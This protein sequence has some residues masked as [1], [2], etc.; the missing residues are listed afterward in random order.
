MAPPVWSVGQVL[1]AADVNSWFIPLVA[2]KTSAQ[3]VTSSTTPVNDTQLFLTLPVNTTYYV[4][5]VVLFD[6]A[7]GGDIKLNIAAPA[8]ATVN[9]TSNNRTLAGVAAN[10][11]PM[12]TNQIASAGS[13]A[14]STL[15]LSFNGVVAMGATAGNIQVVWAQNTSSATATRVLS[16]S[17]LIANR[18]S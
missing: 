6:A 2:L 12:N 18:I 10:W 16:A 8:G 5:G 15:T 13:G 17:V 11:L 7:A 1:A 9:V 3:S 4:Q 14:G